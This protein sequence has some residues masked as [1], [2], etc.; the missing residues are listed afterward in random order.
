MEL[1]EIII[2]EMK[3]GEEK[4]MLK[5]A[6][7]AFHS[8]ESLFVSTPKTAMAAEYE[9]KIVGGMIYQ[10]LDSDYKTVAYVDEA[11]VD[12]DYQGMGIG[13]QL[14]TKTFNH[15]WEQNCDVIT[16]MVKDDNVASWQ[17]AE[18]NHFK[19]VSLN[20]VIKEIGMAAFIKHCFKTPF[21]IAVG[22]D[23]YM[24]DKQ[25]TIKEKKCGLL[26]LFM[27][28]LANILLLMPLWIKHAVNNIND[29]VWSFL[30]YITIL[31]LFTGCRFIGKIISKNEWKFR[32]NNAGGFLPF[33]LSIFGNTF[34][35]NGNWYPE[36]HENT[37]EFKRK[38]AIPEVIKWFVFSLL[39]LFGF[40]RITYC[41]I[42]GNLACFY[43]IF[44]S[45]PIYPF[46][47]LGAGRIYHYNKKLWLVLFI[48]TAAELTMVFKFIS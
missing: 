2:R 34:L 36:K 40:V 41:Q 32:L 15:L 19:R 7:K 8:I 18:D 22:M 27:F 42:L 21:L 48:I 37:V 28:F 10:I 43:L 39:A 14:Y 25:N 4:Q 23:F 5:V 1:S 11:F 46:E 26:Q 33:L 12:S 29:F 6:R 45:V 13:R 16:A 20:Q 38:L 3:P 31:L 35:M 44:M 17:L 24:A 9:G 47:S 30:A